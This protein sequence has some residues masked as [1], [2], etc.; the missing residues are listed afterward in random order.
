MTTQDL[1]VLY[2]LYLVLL[3]SKW[4]SYFYLVPKLAVLLPIPKLWKWLWPP[5]IAHSPKS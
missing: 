2:I 3:L 4:N 1:D 5:S